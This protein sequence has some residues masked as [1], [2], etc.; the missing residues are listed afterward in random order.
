VTYYF[1]QPILPVDTDG[2][3]ADFADLGTA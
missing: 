1:V 2:F 3:I